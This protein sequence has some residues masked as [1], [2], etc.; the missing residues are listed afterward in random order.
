MIVYLE[1]WSNDWKIAQ[2]T[3]NGLLDDVRLFIDECEIGSS[4]TITIDEMTKEEFETL[5]ELEGIE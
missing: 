4:I 3:E 5:E 1:E 2:D